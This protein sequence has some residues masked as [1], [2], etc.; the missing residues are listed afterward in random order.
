MSRKSQ[1]YFSSDNK[2]LLQKEKNCCEKNSETILPT[3]NAGF[4]S[5]GARQPNR[6]CPLASGAFHSL[7]DTDMRDCTP[8]RD[9]TTTAPVAND[10]SAAFV[11]AIDRGRK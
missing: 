10:L 1:F 3:G 4:K 5:A 11:A 7:S 6:K 9:A 8:C 2:K